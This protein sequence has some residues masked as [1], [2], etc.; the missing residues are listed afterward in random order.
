MLKAQGILPQSP[1]P[2]PP[3]GNNLSGPSVKVE[4]RKNKGKGI[5]RERDENADGD[6]IEIISDDDLETLQVTG[7][8]PALLGFLT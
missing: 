7:N 2:S 5:K 4:G 8:A 3:P 1:S 6:V